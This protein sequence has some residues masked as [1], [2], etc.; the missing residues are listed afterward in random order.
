LTASTRWPTLPRTSEITF[1]SSYDQLDHLFHPGSDS[2]RARRFRVFPMDSVSAATVKHTPGPWITSMVVVCPGGHGSP[3]GTFTIHGGP[4]DKFGTQPPLATV[5]CNLVKEF[6]NINLAAEA[7]ARL[8]A[9]APDLLAALQRALNF[10]EGDYQ[11]G[12]GWEQMARAAIAK[13]VQS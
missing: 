7:N 2:G 3:Y 8:I 9:A 4:L 5:H 13:A 12:Q 1:G 11:N 6:E 10:K